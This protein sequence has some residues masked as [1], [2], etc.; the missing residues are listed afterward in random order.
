MVKFLLLVLG[1]IQAETVQWEETGKPQLKAEQR[2]PKDFTVF[3]PPQCPYSQAGEG[4][5]R[6]LLRN[7]SSFVV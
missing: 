7:T 1:T 6:E 3:L 4:L 5:R 2:E